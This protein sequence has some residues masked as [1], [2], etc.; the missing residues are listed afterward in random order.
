MDGARGTLKPAFAGRL[1]RSSG[2]PWARQ[3]IIAGVLT[4]VAIA[5]VVLATTRG[6]Q[7]SPAAPLALAVFLVVPAWMF[8]SHRPEVSL[9]VFVVYVGLFDGLIKLMTAS[10]LATIGRDA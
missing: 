7:Y 2:V 10:Q 5:L 4:V 3:A 6:T 8:I 9:A 1:P